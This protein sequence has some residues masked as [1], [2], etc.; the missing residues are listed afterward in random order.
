MEIKN[1]GLYIQK[2]G[3]L[4]HLK[5]YVSEYQK[6]SVLAD[7]YVFEKYRKTIVNGLREDVQFV[8]DMQD[9]KD[10]DV[11]V[12]IGGGKMMDQAKFAAHQHD[13]ACI[14]VP[15][16]PASDAPCTSVAVIDGEYIECGCPQKV[17]ADEVI[18]SQVPL[19]F[20]ISGLGDGL[21]TYYE[22]RHYKLPASIETLCC[23]CKDT[24]LKY[25]IQAKA[26]F[27]EGLMSEALS[28]CFE[29][30]LYMSGTAFANS[31]GSGAH[32][33]SYGLSKGCQKALHG[34]LVAFSLLIQLFMENDES[35]HEL[36][37]FYHI[38]GLPCHLKDLGLDDVSDEE[39]L[40]MIDESMS[41]KYSMNR[42]P[43]VIQRDDVLEA[44]RLVDAFE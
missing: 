41:K 19:R 34:E 12:G 42:M 27:E 22:S 30:I 15:T 25:G 3:L 26:D 13:A 36:R 14:L 16:S 6:I 7:V 23:M 9:I 35:I 40:E 38:V 10:C 32:A 29:A 44:I 37:E 43:M 2:D 28:K 8:F 4:S 33:L 18:L 20:F 11:V 17:L 31:G 5:E 21:S 1:V 39:L 24:I